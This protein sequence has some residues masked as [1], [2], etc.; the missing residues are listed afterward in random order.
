MGRTKTKPKKHPNPSV[1]N[2]VAGG[3]PLLEP[4]PSNKTVQSLLQRGTLKDSDSVGTPTKG[5]RNQTS[6]NSPSR[7]AE[8][9]AIKQK[10]EP[11]G[12]PEGVN[13]GLHGTREL[14][15]GR[16]ILRTPEDKIPPLKLPPPI[17]NEK[18][19]DACMTADLAPLYRN[20]KKALTTEKDIL[21]RDEAWEPIPL[22]WPV[23][24]TKKRMVIAGHI[25]YNGK[26]PETIWAYPNLDQESAVT[27]PVYHEGPMTDEEEEDAKMQAFEQEYG[28]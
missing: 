27:E 9:Q 7:N 4:A 23:P 8:N 17:L 16:G 11:N 19:M 10:T 3:H 18:L 12:T 26:P 28:P 22:N 15:D 5:H 14:C 2:A 13:L 1:K 20:F 6:T 25:K 21:E 24:P